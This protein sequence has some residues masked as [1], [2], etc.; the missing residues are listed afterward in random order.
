[1]QVH[2]LDSPEQAL[3]VIPIFYQPIVPRGGG[4]FI[5]PE[6]IPMIAKYLAAHPEGVLPMHVD[7]KPSTSAYANKEDD[8]GYFST[9]KE[10]KRCS[11]FVEVTGDVGDVVLMHPLM[12]HT[13][14]K[15][16]LR[17]A[18]VIT[19]PALALKEP[20]NFNRA[21]PED[22][23]LVERKT[24]AALGVDKLDFQ[25][26]TAR[27]R[28]VPKRVS[29]Q[30]ALFEAETKRLAELEAKRAQQAPMESSAKPVAVA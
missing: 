16:H 22:Y 4:T 18:R 26:M 28:L 14:S 3:L 20:H 2:F 11:N 13:A 25:I 8:P 19:N 23:S 27:R 5:C 29:E 1:M 30:Q 17:R 21:N 24:L 7:F 10:I 6:G 12:L 15:N 9:L